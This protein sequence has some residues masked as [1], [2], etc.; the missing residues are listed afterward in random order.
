MEEKNTLKEKIVVFHPALAPYRVDLFNA[1][2]QKFD[3]VIYFEYN[4]VQDQKFDQKAILSQ[5]LF[6]VK[7]ISKGFKIRNRSVRFGVIEILKRE[8]P[9]IV[10]CGEYGF[11]TILS[12]LHYKLSKKKYRLYTMRD[13]KSVV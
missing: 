13:R 6:P 4:N 12:F 2:S 8:K 9:N 3:L 7:Y 5:L 10:I 11:S 1:L